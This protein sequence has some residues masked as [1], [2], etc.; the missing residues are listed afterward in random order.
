MPL[1]PA[2]NM[3]LVP[4]YFAQPGA[5]IRTEQ[6]NPPLEDISNVMSMHLVRDGRN[7]MV[8]TLN[9]GTFTI[10]N[11]GAG[12]DPTDA[13]TISQVTGAGPLGIIA[14]FAGATAPTGWMLCYGQAISRTTYAALFAVIGTAWGVGDGSTTFNLPDFRGRVGAGKDDMG[15]S[16]AGRL[17][18]FFGAAARSIGG[19]LGTAAHILTL[20]QMARHSHG[21]NDP[22]HS[23]SRGGQ[24]SGGVR[25]AGQGADPGYAGES[26]T[27]LSFTGISI[28]QSGGDEAHPN[29]QPTLIV[30]KIIRVTL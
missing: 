30:N 4:T 23:H 26:A 7:G 25:Y 17:S 11:V 20:G 10:K 27:G 19:A 3:S 9:M 13:A 15:G 21:V 1:D 29:A 22:S 12:V 24:Q 28:Q 16:D 2:G 18:T 8:G 14:D 6:H 5:T